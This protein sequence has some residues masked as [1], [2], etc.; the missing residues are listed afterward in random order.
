MT[1]DP[2]LE[3]MKKN[4]ENFKAGVDAVKEIIKK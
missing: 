1:E 3:T 2:S 4:I